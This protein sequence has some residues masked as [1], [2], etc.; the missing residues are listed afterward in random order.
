M[1]RTRLLRR[2]RVVALGKF[3]LV[4]IILKVGARG[5]GFVWETIAENIT[6]I[7]P[8]GPFGGGVG[9]HSSRQRFF[10]VLRT[11]GYVVF[12]CCLAGTSFSYGY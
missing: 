10:A 3:F 1:A 8:D 5:T 2:F 12:S 4:T 7:L 11:R 9:E 6:R